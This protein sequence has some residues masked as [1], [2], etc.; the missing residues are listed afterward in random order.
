MSGI[1]PSFVMQ[2]ERRMRA[3][4]ET[5]YVRRLA[6]E[7]MWWNRVMRP[8][9]IQGRTERMTWFLDTATISPAGPDYNGTMTFED[10]VTQTA[11]YPTFHHNKG[12]RVSVDEL[13][14]LDGTGLNQLAKWSE[15][16]GNETAYYPQV[17]AAQLILN[18]SATDLTANAYDGVPF[19]TA[20]ATGNPHYVNPFNTNAGG[21]YNDLTGAAG[22]GANILYPGAVDI[23]ETVT[24][25]VA[26]ANLN[27]V[28]AYIA[29]VKMPNGRDPRFLKPAFILAPPKLMPRLSQLTDAKFIAQAAT[30]G[31]AGSADIIAY[32]SRL[33]LGQPVRVDEFASSQTYSG[34][35]PFVSSGGTVTYKDFSASGSDTTYYV[36]CQ[37]MQTTQLGGLLFVQRE[38]FKVNYYTGDGGGTG[39]D[40]VLQ[41]A[42]IVEYQVDGRM[43]AQYGHPYTIF[44][45]RA[46]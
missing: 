9:P 44:K 5:E 1:T 39:M 29:S 10:M 13:K 45:C 12:I 16:I 15:N 2:Y 19:F 40:A 32:I 35:Q 3:I 21:F 6:S 30:G 22:S 17:L 23:S 41:R 4:T 34:S 26:L 38:P 42:K 25:D 7:S 28:V 8:T 11:E 33:G 46:A 20:L 18:G 43:S 31:G 27:K 24:A 36:V 37:E 14:D